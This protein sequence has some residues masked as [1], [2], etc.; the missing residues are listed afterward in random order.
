MQVTWNE[1][2]DVDIRTVDPD[3]LVDM[4]DVNIDT[5]LQSE[6]RIE[7][8]IEQIKNPLCYKKNGIIVKN[9]YKSGGAKLEDCFK[10]IVM[11]M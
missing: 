7:Q 9:V 10:E 2:Y 8:F 6:K 5:S 3:T 11:T 4:D 1:K